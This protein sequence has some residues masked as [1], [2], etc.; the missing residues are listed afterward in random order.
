[1]WSQGQKGICFTIVLKILMHDF[2][3]SNCSGFR[4]FDDKRAA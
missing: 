1:M 2:L 4:V 3:I